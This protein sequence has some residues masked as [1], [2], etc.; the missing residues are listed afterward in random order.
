MQEPEKRPGC[1][2]PL[3][4][5]SIIDCQKTCSPKACHQGIQLSYHIFR[6][7]RVRDRSCRCHGSCRACWTSCSRW[8]CR[9]CWACGRLLQSGL[10]G[11]PLRFLLSDPSLPPDPAL[12][13]LQPGLLLRLPLSVPSDLLLRSLLLLPPGP[14]L[15]SLRP[16][17][18]VPS[19]PPDPALLSLQPDLPDPA[20]P[21]APVGPC[22]PASPAGPAGPTAPVAP[23]GPVAPTGPCAPVA[24]TGPCAPVGPIGPCAPSYPGNPCGPVLAPSALLVPLAPGIPADLSAPSDLCSSSFHPAVRSFRRI[25][26]P[27]IHF[28][29][30][31][32]PL[33]SRHHD[34]DHNPYFSYLNLLLLIFHE[35]SVTGYPFTILYA[36][37]PY[38]FLLSLSLHP[39]P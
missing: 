3:R 11:L 28:H 8:A 36:A 10:S 13:P 16:G 12:L 35:Y 38:S 21:V 2:S 1:R 9:P 14:V 20:A 27:G 7:R 15:P 19:L 32:A 30:D 18:S 24:P 37:R 34:K 26:R 33:Y 39:R 5:F 4:A 23:V 25:P 17:L 29:S 22:A 6:A 31:F